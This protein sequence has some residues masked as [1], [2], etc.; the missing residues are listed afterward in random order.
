MS[1]SGQ[2]RDEL[3]RHETEA[4]HCN[5]A[6][7]SALIKMSGEIKIFKHACAV[8]FHTENLGV[9][10]KCFTLLTKTFNIRTD[11]VVRRNTSRDNYSYYI[12]AKGNELLAI[13]DTIVQAVCC[14]RA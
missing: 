14:K 1:F 6:E 9:A 4:R 3:S 7:L 2:I 5:L 12:Y 8:R 10:R 13:R 11:I